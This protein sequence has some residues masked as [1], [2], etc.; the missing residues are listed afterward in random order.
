MQLV[1][2]EAAKRFVAKPPR[3]VETV[4][5]WQMDNRVIGKEVTPPPT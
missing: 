4:N 5:C 2:F 1:L 3:H